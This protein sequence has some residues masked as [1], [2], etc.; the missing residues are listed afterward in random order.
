MN[1]KC[2]FS[3]PHSFLKNYKKEFNSIIKTYFKEIWNK[4]ALK[5]SEDI[6]CWI[7]NPGQNF[8]I[9][10]KVLSFFPNLEVIITPSTG[11]NH[12]DENKCLKKNINVYGL[13]DNRK[14]LNT[15]TASSEF[16][17]LLILNSLR[18]LDFALN[19]VNNRRW[20]ENEDDL[21]GYELNGR[22]IGI[23]GL[24]R[25]GSNIARWSKQFGANVIFYDP[26]SDNK[27]Y[28]SVSLKNIF[29]LSDIVCISCILSEETFNFI[30]YKLLKNMK[31]NSV[32]IN[33]SRGEV[34]N[35]N[36]LLKLLNERKDIFVS[37]DVLSGEVNNTHLSSP[38]ISLHKEGRIVI[39]PHISG[40]T[41]DSQIKAARGAYQILN[42]YYEFK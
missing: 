34:I 41:I 29:T 37:L 17:F 3:A 10:N 16:T 24:G 8:I 25:I 6:T 11:K 31:K 22:T 4:N 1:K 12:I 38:L 14:L 5:F 33:T 27:N 42:K 7:V 39:T 2:L 20:R 28:K 30:N 23:V 36:D 19:E 40:A 13:L 26:Y 15:I 18:R 21:R 32:L 35:E 9:D